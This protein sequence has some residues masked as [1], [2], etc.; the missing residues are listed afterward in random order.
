MLLSTLPYEEH[1]G[2]RKR[3]QKA[4]LDDFIDLCIIKTQRMAQFDAPEEVKQA[5][6]RLLAAI[7]N[8]TALPSQS[9]Q[10]EER[11]KIL[12]SENQGTIG[13]V[14]YSTDLFSKSALSEKEKRNGPAE[15][16][17]E[18][19]APNATPPPPFKS[20]QEAL[21]SPA[22]NKTPSTRSSLVALALSPYPDCSNQD[23]V[24]FP[25]VGSFSMKTNTPDVFSVLGSDLPSLNQTLELEVENF[26]RG[27]ITPCTVQVTTAAQR[28]NKCLQHAQHAEEACSATRHASGTEATQDV[29]SA[30]EQNAMSLRLLKELKPHAALI[31]AALRTHIDLAIINNETCKFAQEAI[32]GILQGCLD[33]YIEQAYESE[34]QRAEATLVWSSFELQGSLNADNE[35]QN[36]AKKLEEDVHQAVAERQLFFIQNSIPLIAEMLAR[37]HLLLELLKGDSL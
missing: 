14:P 23:D 34:L 26:L 10:P 37:P 32:D 6:C 16:I 1:F 15:T 35:L 29:F 13:E 4:S 21:S 18:N 3:Q 20:R 25:S 30:D 22:S 33:I 36:R 8:R 12:P 28:G 9:R 31:Q 7:N 27:S 24:A 2:S 11:R 5:A 17:D 19:A